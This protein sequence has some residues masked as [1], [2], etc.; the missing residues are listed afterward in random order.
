MKMLVFYAK[1]M[2]PCA[3]LG[4]LLDLYVFET[5][6]VA[7]VGIFIGSVIASARLPKKEK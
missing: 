1:F 4:L 7:Y 3:M 5:K 6:F 2:I